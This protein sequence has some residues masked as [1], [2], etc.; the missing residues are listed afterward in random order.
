MLSVTLWR[1][2]TVLA[3]LLTLVGAVLPGLPSAPFL[4][5]AAATAARGWPSFEARLLAHPRHG[6]VIHRWRSRR[7]VPRVAKR[8]ATLMMMASATMLWLSPAPL[9]LKWLVPPILLAVA[10]WLWSRPDE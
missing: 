7:A 6:P 9:P 4:L 2:C 5:L 10:A 1:S 8:L 3:I